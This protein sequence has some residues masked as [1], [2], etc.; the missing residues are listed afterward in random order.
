MFVRHGTRIKLISILPAYRQTVDKGSMHQRSNS[1]NTSATHI[2]VRGSSSQT[3]TEKL[4]AERWS[5]TFAPL[6]TVFRRHAEA[7]S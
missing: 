2:I 4:A 6:R 7:G 3:S 1:F 5:I